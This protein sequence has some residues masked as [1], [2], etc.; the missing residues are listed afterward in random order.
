MSLIQSYERETPAS[1][2]S[3]PVELQWYI[4]AQCS[5][6]PTTLQLAIPCRCYSRSLSDPIT[7]P[8][9][10]QVSALSQVSAIT[11]K[12]LAGLVQRTVCFAHFEGERADLRTNVPCSSL[13][14]FGS[15]TILTV[16]FHCFHRV[17]AIPSM[18]T[19]L[20][21][22]FQALSKNSSG[23]QPSV[24]LQ[25]DAALPRIEKTESVDIIEL[26][27]APLV[28]AILLQPLG[29]LHSTCK[30]ELEVIRGRAA[31]PWKGFQVVE[32][33]INFMV[34]TLRRTNPGCMTPSPRLDLCRQLADD[35]YDEGRLWALFHDVEVSC[36]RVVKTFA[37][38]QF[39]DK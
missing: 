32:D 37:L 11:R 2:L 27:R 3:L 10:C 16:N 17:A 13:L 25:L 24:R 38:P 7:A 15:P 9:Q 5:E 33:Y 35:L 22:I 31:V 6:Y 20:T 12:N 34:E 18:W 26:E 30:V 8:A 19:S 28:V 14:S 39:G 29:L 23:Q 1:F 36:K 4:F 21:R